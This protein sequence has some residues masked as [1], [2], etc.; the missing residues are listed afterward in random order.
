M[1]NTALSCVRFVRGGGRGPARSWCRRRR[2]E[3]PPGIQLNVPGT[4][5]PTCHMVPGLP[6][7]QPLHRCSGSLCRRNAKAAPH[8]VVSLFFFPTL[9][10]RMRILIKRPTF[11][12]YITKCEIVCQGYGHGTRSW[13]RADLDGQTLLECLRVFSDRRAYGSEIRRYRFATYQ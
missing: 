1:I 6:E 5:R 12:H 9:L 13:K 2:S 8:P 3:A 4:G 10:S 11:S 7:R